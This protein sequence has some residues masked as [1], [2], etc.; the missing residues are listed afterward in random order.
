MAYFDFRRL[1]N[2]YSRSFTVITKG[3]GGYNKAGDYVNGETTETVLKG[4]IIGLNEKKI[5]RSGGTLTEQ[6]R[7]LYMLQPLDNALM[8]STVL[9][10]G[11]LYRIEAEQGGGNADFTNVWAYTLKYVSAFNE[12]GGGAGV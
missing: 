8:S 2:K 3:K 6:D 10:Q 11:N 7:A 5:Y 12:K 1:V 9:F 4:A